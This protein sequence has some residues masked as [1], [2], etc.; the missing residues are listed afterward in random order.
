[1]CLTQCL[2]PFSKSNEKAAGITSGFSA[3]YKRLSLA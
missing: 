3:A 2:S 1:M